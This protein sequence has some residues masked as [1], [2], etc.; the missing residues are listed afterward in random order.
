MSLWN[1]DA[2]KIRF[3][4]ELVSILVFVDVALEQLHRRFPLLPPQ[5]SI[6]VFVDV[7]LE[8]S[9]AEDHAGTEPVFQ[10]LFS[11]MSLW[12]GNISSWKT[13][14]SGVSILVFVDVALELKIQEFVIGVI[15]CFNPCFRGCRSGTLDEPK[16]TIEVKGFNPCFRGCRSGTIQ[17][18]YPVIKTPKFQSL[19]SWMSLWNGSRAIRVPDGNIVSILVFVDVA[20]ER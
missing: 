14:G 3:Y 6:L 12:N 20:L 1:V 16:R 7:A 9:C 19:F 17:P 13:D 8:L 2:G 11:W 10:S 5:V 18:L 15:L 4:V